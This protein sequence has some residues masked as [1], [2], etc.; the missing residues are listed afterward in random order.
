MDDPGKLERHWVEMRE[1]S[2]G[3]RL[4]LR[5]ADAPLPPARGRRGLVLRPGNVAEALSPGA[6]DRSVGTPG[7]W[8]LQGDTLTV[9]APGWAG[10]YRVRFQD[11]DKLVLEKE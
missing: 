7:T 6:A 8:S 10:R 4:V 3:D 11:P 1:E 9:S 5:P 2:Q